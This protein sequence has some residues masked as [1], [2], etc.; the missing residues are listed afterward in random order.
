[1][2]WVNKSVNGFKVWT[3]TVTLVA[4]GTAY[5]SEIDF[6]PM[7]EN[8]N[9]YIGIACVA[10]AVSGTNLD[11]SLLGS[12]AQG[13]A[14]ASMEYTHVSDALVADITNSAKTKSALVDFNL[15]PTPYYKIG[16]LV[17]ASEA[18]NTVAVTIAVPD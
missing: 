12:A 2:S 5:T 8:N 16:F 6:V 10:S 18:A 13:T 7:G 17:D 9:H 15:Y 14:D 1:M 11:V 4:S 3:E